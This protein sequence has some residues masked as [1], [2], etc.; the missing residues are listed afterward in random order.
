M[1]LS[2][3][4]GYYSSASSSSGASSFLFRLSSFSCKFVLHFFFFVYCLS[5]LTKHTIIN[6]VAIYIYDYVVYC[7]IRVKMSQL[8]N[9]TRLVA[10]FWLPPYSL[11]SSPY[12][13]L[14]LHKRS[15]HRLYCIRI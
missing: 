2:I 8:S 11:L 14:L 9:S 1:C 7:D 6:V 3:L 5:F 4:I 10:S 13:F 15:K 12:I